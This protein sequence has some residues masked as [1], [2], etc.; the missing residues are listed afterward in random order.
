MSSVDG[1][2]WDIAEGGYGWTTKD[3]WVQK[4]KDSNKKNTTTLSLVEL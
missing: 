4:K 2:D 1:M 3:F